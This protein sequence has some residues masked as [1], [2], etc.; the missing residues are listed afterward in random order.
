[1]NDPSLADRPETYIDEEVETLDNQ[2]YDGEIMVDTATVGETLVGISTHRLL[3][4]TPE[5]TD[6]RR[7][8]SVALPNVQGF[9][10]ATGGMAAFRTRAIQAG[11]YTALLIG[12]GL[13]V[14]L[15][16]MITTVEPPQGTGLGPVLNL[17]DLLIA[18]LGFVDEFL[19]GLGLLAL[20]VTVYYVGRYLGSRNRYFEVI[21]AGGDPVRIPLDAG[22]RPPVDRLEEAVEKA[23]NTSAP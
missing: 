21:I 15:Q 14:D 16:G 11:I 8:R 2:L 10:T 3:S 4:L 5:T 20:M 9:R 19:L 13:L 6:R 23:S 18:S 22:A 7:F 12:A 17:V 1:M